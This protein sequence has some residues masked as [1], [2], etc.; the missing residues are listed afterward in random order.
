M[1]VG[2]KAPID[3]WSE[4]KDDDG[5]TYYHNPAQN[6]GK[7]QWEKPEGY[8]EK[9]KKGQPAPPSGDPPAKEEKDKYGSHRKG[10]I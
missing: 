10:W 4:Y 9:K 7:S 2:E 5:D 8:D 6:G 1:V 3:E